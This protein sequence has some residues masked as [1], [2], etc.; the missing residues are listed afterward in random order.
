MTDDEEEMLRKVRI[1]DAMPM[2]ERDL[3]LAVAGEL[4][5]LSI[6]ALEFCEVVVSVLRERR[7]ELDP[8]AVMAA[9][10]KRWQARKRVN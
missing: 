9:V 4:P 5:L 10:L 8:I 1:I 2:S 3:F 7:D 6:S